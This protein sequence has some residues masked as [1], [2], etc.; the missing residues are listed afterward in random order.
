[1]SEI[2]RCKRNVALMHASWSEANGSVEHVAQSRLPVQL[3]DR[4][5]EFTAHAF[6]ANVR[7]TY[8]EFLAVVYRDH[9][10]HLMNGDLLPLV[11]LHSACV[12]GDGL[13]SL[14]CDCGPQLQYSL[15]TIASYGLGILIY[16]A[17]E[18]GRAIGLVEKIR[19]Y[20][21]QDQG[22]DTVDANLAL[23]FGVDDR[24]F[25]L[26][27]VILKHFGVSALKLLTNNPDKVTALRLAGL[28][29]VRVPMPVFMTPRN[30]AYLLTKQ[31]RMGHL[32]RE[33]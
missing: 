17:N 5:V 12:T 20:A 14:R 4:V 10:R 29:V 15:S 8:D 24:R 16:A 22:L 27:A 3:D 21:L 23:G 31:V 9:E 19:A 7:S 13:G 11:R 2:G 25:S 1:M 28:A 32:Y 30:R 6:R 18:E 26:A 33:V